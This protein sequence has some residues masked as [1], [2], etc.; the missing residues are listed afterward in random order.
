[1]LF[2]ICLKKYE[3]LLKK[4]INCLAYLTKNPKPKKKKKI[5]V[6]IIFRNLKTVPNQKNIN[7]KNFKNRN[8]EKI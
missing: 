5:N 4:K 8:K 3:K 6:Y 1:M 7:L 2:L